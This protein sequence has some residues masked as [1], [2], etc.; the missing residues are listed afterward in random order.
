MGM[1]VHP[2]TKA[3]DDLNAERRVYEEDVRDWCHG[4]GGIMPYLETSYCAA[5]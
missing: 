1:Y 4:D 5:C 3:E 2:G